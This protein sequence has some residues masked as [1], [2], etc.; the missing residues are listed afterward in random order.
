ML[1]LDKI[2]KLF[3]KKRFTLDVLTRLKKVRSFKDVPLY[4]HCH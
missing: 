1:V 3:G 2:S 4:L